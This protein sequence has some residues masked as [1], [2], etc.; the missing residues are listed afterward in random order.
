MEG[1]IDKY[2]SFAEQ[3]RDIVY[4]YAKDIREQLYVAYTTTMTT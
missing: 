3:A 4:R 1:L 2:V